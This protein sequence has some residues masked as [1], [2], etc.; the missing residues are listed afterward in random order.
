MIQDKENF[1]PVGVGRSA[2]VKGVGSKWVAM[3]TYKADEQPKLLVKEYRLLTITSQNHCLWCSD[4]NF[5]EILAR[6]VGK[7]SQK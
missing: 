2:D 3:V 4:P 5:A 7:C 1:S 6:G